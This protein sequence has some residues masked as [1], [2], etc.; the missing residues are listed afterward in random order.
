[1]IRGLRRII[2]IPP[3]VPSIGGKDPPTG[4]RCQRRAPRAARVVRGLAG[5]LLIALAAGCAPLPPAA[6]PET[7][8]SGAFVYLVN[9]GWHVG[10]AVERQEGSPAIRPG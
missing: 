9:H 3:W 4:P 2:V 5:L 1:M 6:P 10:M 8:L 7:P